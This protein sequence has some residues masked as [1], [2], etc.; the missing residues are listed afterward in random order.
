VLIRILTNYLQVLVLVSDFELNWPSQVKDVFDS[1]SY[2]T[3]S[4]EEFFSFDCIIKQLG[5]TSMSSYYLKVIF[6]GLLPII[7]SIIA[8][9]IWLLIKISC[10]NWNKFSLW[11]NIQISCQVLIFLFYPKITKMVGS[12]V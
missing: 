3:S 7:L 6:F 10:K 1:A 9:F 11:N 5:I 8:G 2:L 4:S 12:L